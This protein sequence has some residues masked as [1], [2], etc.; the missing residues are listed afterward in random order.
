MPGE[1]QESARRVRRE[2]ATG[3]SAGRESARRESARREPREG[4][5][6]KRQVL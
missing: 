1:S 5:Y 3:E 4:A 6:D 2:S